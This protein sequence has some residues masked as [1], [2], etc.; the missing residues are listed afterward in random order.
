MLH[1]LLICRLF[2]NDEI[3][4]SYCGRAEA[5]SSARTILK[6]EGRCAEQKPRISPLT[7]LLAASA[8]ED[9]CSPRLS[10]CGKQNCHSVRSQLRVLT[11]SVS[12][13]GTAGLLLPQCRLGTR[14]KRDFCCFLCNEVRIPDQMLELLASTWRNRIQSLGVFQRES[15]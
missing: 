2:A 9:P 5:S 3:L 4:H 10:A 14:N 1:I 15:R 7:L 8:R 12:S 13:S 6:R 11:R